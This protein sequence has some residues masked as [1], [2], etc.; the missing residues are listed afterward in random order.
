MRIVHRTA[1]SKMFGCE[2][3]FWRFASASASKCTYFAVFGGI[4]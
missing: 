3:F 1:V 4:V 2:T